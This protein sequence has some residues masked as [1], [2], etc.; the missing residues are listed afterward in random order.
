[1][2]CS[3]PALSRIHLGIPST[4]SHR[5]GCPGAAD[6][7]QVHCIPGVFINTSHSQGAVSCLL[8]PLTGP[9]LAL[10]ERGEEFLLALSTWARCLAGWTGQISH[11]ASS[12]SSRVCPD[13]QTPAVQLDGQCRFAVRSNQEQSLRKR[14]S[15]EPCW[16]WGG[17]ASRVRDVCHPTTANHSCPLFLS[18]PP[19]A[20]DLTNTH[21][22]P[23]QRGHVGG[24]FS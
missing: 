4:L 20:R 1:M 17:R 21:P 9:P 23:G 5:P 22:H 7:S 3:P 12:Q 18:T 19:T 13:S 14:H 10:T 2:P 15:I 11:L 6:P 8:I 16:G 24:S